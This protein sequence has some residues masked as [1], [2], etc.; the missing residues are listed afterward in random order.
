[1]GKY[2]PSE[3]WQRRIVIHSFKNCRFFSSEPKTL[4]ESKLFV[5]DFR[6]NRMPWKWS[7]IVCVVKYLQCFFLF[8][9]TSYDFKN[10]N[11]ITIF[12]FVNVYKIRGSVLFTNRLKEDECRQTINQSQKLIMEIILKFSLSTST[13]TIFNFINV[14]DIKRLFLQDKI[15]LICNK[16]IKLNTNRHNRIIF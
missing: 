3:Y 11:S 7:L 10:Y 6:D 15:W 1:M 16:T 14:M 9:K 5:M 8:K 2:F 12:F 13:E 4:K